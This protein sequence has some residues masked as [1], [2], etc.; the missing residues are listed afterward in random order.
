M[1]EQQH[2]VANRGTNAFGLP[3][4]ESRPVG[5]VFDQGD[6]AIAGLQL[7]DGAGPKL[8]FGHRGVHGR[9]S[10]GC[11]YISVAS[12]AVSGLVG[13]C[14]IRAF[15]SLSSMNHERRGCWQRRCRGDRER[16]GGCRE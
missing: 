7:A 14:R 16:L 12:I 11:I 6:R 15:L 9:R 1:L 3:G 13:V 5:I 8:L 4:V 10:A 2:P